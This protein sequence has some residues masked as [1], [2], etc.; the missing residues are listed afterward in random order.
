MQESLYFS[1]QLQKTHPYATASFQYYHSFCSL[2]TQSL[3]RVFPRRER[4]GFQI[5]MWILVMYFSSVASLLCK[6]TSQL[7]K[8]MFPE[9]I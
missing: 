4:F 3:N 5:A 8:D 6:M 9:Y 1:P 2:F 7:A